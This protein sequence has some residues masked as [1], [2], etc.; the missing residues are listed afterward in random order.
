MIRSDGCCRTV[1]QLRILK[2]PITYQE[3][4]ELIY[5]PA[6]IYIITTLVISLPIPPILDEQIIHIQPQYMI[7]LL[8]YHPPNISVHVITIAIIIGIPISVHTLSQ[9]DKGMGCDPTHFP[10][11]MCTLASK[12]SILD[13][14]IGL[15][16]M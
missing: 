3:E 2:Q 13:R 12:S 4:I 16:N 11:H 15:E 1:D 10:Y 5:S 6:K 9:Q 7:L 14:T 8:P